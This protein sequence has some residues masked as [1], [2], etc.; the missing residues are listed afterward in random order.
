M[1]DI[2]K[3]TQLV[4]A[5]LAIV[6]GVMLIAGGC[7]SAGVQPASGA[8]TRQIVVVYGFS[9]EE[10]AFTEEIFPAFQTYWQQQTGQ[11]VTFHSVF[12]GSE[13]LTEAIIGGAPA[14]VA[15]MSNEQHAIWLRVNDLVET[16]WHALPN[17]GVVTSS[18][19]VIVVRPGNPLGI[20]DWA[21]LARSSVKLVHPDPRTSGGAQW[22]LL[23]EYG[24]AL[25]GRDDDVEM[26]REQLR[27][28]WANA[29]ATP[30]SSREALKQFMFGVGDA[31]ITYEQDALLARSRGAELEI[32]M[33]SSTIMSEHVV[34]LVDKNIKSWERETVDAFVDFLWSERVQAALT[35]YYFRAVTDEGLN[36][37]VPEFHEIEQLLTV[38]E[39]GGWGKA[40]PEII[41]WAVEEL[42]TE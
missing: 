7:Q 23:A 6:F 27:S 30:S 38:E 1:R 13:Q 12:T 10:E 11:E 24:S 28:I 18:P 29:I 9:I 4:V 21:D 31:L 14:D 26:A 2:P 34:V 22:A 17:E 35:R 42:I 25:Q 5:A 33:P 3:A 39:L 40:Y 37:A 36:E 8:P 32:V 19:L 20:T 16:D 41:H 15:I